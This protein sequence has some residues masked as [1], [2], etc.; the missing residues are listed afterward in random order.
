PVPDVAGLRPTPDRVR[1]TLFNW[2]QPVI[3]GACC[4]DLYAG[5]GIL[6]LEAVS[7]GAAEAILVEQDPSLLAQIRRSIELLDTGELVRVEQAEALAW[8]RHNQ[9]RFD[10]VFLDPPFGQGLIEKSANLLK[11]RDCL[12]PY[13][14][15][16]ME[17]EP[18]LQVPDG[19]RVHR[20]SKAGKVKFMLVELL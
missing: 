17:S 1:E 3:T 20:Q 12:Q 15:I 6:G 9:T 16:Y 13:A 14:M 7:R 2:L 19:F 5:T 10:L 4:L 18:E 11:E 8:L